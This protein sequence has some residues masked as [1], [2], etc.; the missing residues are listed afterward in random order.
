MNKN[1]R[2]I[3]VVL[4]CMLVSAGRSFAGE[5]AVVDLITGI[6]SAFQNNT[7]S[8]KEWRV[9][10]TKSFPSNLYD[11][12]E[13]HTIYKAP[14]HV[15]WLLEILDKHNPKKLEKATVVCYSGT[16]F[17]GILKGLTPGMSTQDMDRFFVKPRVRLRG[18]R[19]YDSTSEVEQS[20]TFKFVGGK[21]RMLT[22]I[23]W[24]DGGGHDEQVL[25][26]LGEK[27]DETASRHLA[28]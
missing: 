17:G 9:V 6:D 27:F 16:E 26:Y 19:H 4:F 1:I 15:V 28:K 23:N 7:L 5:Q 20:V 11:T 21:S 13:K 3:V 25:R 12:I 24:P 10:T 22:F 18:I 14:G 8:D 2:C